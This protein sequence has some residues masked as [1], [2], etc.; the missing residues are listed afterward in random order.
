M[1]PVRTPHASISAELN[2]NSVYPSA[3]PTLASPPSP[4]L[5][6]QVATATS[7]RTT[8]QAGLHTIDHTTSRLEPLPW[9][10]PADDESD[11]PLEDDAV[12]NAPKDAASVR[13]QRV[14]R[15]AAL[16]K[17]IEHMV[18][19]PVPVDQWAV[20]Y[21]FRGKFRDT[22]NVCR[23]LRASKVFKST[24]ERPGEAYHKCQWSDTPFDCK[25]WDTL[26]FTEQHRLLGQ[27]MQ[28]RSM[29][30]Y[31]AGYGPT[32]PLPEGICCKKPIRL[33]PLKQL[34][35]E[36]ANEE[37]RL[38]Y[39]DLNDAIRTSRE[40]GA[41]ARAAAL[42]QERK[43][44]DLP[45]QRSA[46]PGKRPRP[47]D[48]DEE[49]QASS[50]HQ[51]RTLHIDAHAP[52][53]PQESEQPPRSTFHMVDHTVSDTFTSPAS[54]P[55]SNS[56]PSGRT[57][58]PL[59]QSVVPPPQP[60]NPPPQPI[61][62][63]PQPIPP[64]PQ[65]INPPPQTMIDRPLT[66]TTPQSP[67]EKLAHIY[68]LTQ[69]LQYLLE[70]GISFGPQPPSPAPVP[71]NRASVTHAPTP[72]RFV[73]ETPG[74]WSGAS[75]QSVLSD[76]FPP[77]TSTDL[78]DLGQLALNVGISPCS[79]LSPHEGLP[80][81][82][83]SD[84]SIS[85]ISTDMQYLNDAIAKMGEPY[86][87][88]PA[89]TPGPRATSSG[90]S[91]LPPRTPENTASNP[92]GPY[93]SRI[94]AW[95]GAYE[96]WRLASH[97]DAPPSFVDLSLSGGDVP[98][99]APL[100]SG[101]T[102]S[103]ERQ[104]AAP[105]TTSPPPHSSV[106]VYPLHSRNGR[107]GDPPPSEDGSPASSSSPDAAAS[108]AESEHTSD[109]SDKEPAEH[110]VRP[111]Q[112]AEF[113]GAKLPDGTQEDE[114]D[115]EADAKEFQARARALASAY[116]QHRYPHAGGSLPADGRTAIKFARQM[117]RGLIEFICEQ[118]N[119]QQQRVWKE[120]GAFVGW[121]R[122]LN[123]WNMFQ[124]KWRDDLPPG[125]PFDHEAC[126]AAYIEEASNDPVEFHSRLS[127]WHEAHTAPD[128]RDLLPSERAKLMDQLLK[129]S[130]YMFSMYD[131][132][133][134]IGARLEVGS[135]HPLEG[136]TMY[137]VYETKSMQGYTNF[138]YKRTHAG[139]KIAWVAFAA[140]RAHALVNNPPPPTVDRRVPQN[141]RSARAEIQ[142]AGRALARPLPHQLS[143]EL[144]N[145]VEGEIT[146]IWRAFTSVVP[147]Q[148][149][150]V[151]AWTDAAVQNPQRENPPL[152]VTVSGRRWTWQDEQ[153]RLAGNIAE[154]PMPQSMVPEAPQSTAV[155]KTVQHRTGKPK[156]KLRDAH[157]R[158]A[159]KTA[160]SPPGPLR[161]AVRTDVVPSDLRSLTTESPAREVSH[162]PPRIAL[163]RKALDTD[164]AP[165]QGDKSTD[166]PPGR[167][168]RLDGRGGRSHTRSSR[169]DPEAEPPSQA[170]GAPVQRDPVAASQPS[171]RPTGAHPV[172][173]PS[174]RELD[175]MVATHGSPPPSWNQS[176][177]GE[178][179]MSPRRYDVPVYDP[180][181]P[182]PDAGLT[183]KSQQRPRRPGPTY[184]TVSTHAGR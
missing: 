39:E 57:N 14:A 164:A 61:N 62:P 73:P 169:E 148:A 51:R 132:T 67:E 138:A 109:S 111:S 56:Q 59:A 72:S 101:F 142:S 38:K 133:C 93:A 159:P 11:V 115:E 15:I 29:A 141:M 155:Q 166:P 184:A 147:S 92:E 80:G 1:A 2:R 97:W 179:A 41:A 53:T 85:S 99:I 96:E 163:K 63:P 149:L 44:T 7:A 30:D 134:H 130:T 165:L 70:S 90:D 131:R 180:G 145:S 25:F 167:R 182:L 171:A 140:K 173:L 112:D 17:S 125:T 172:T 152:I 32:V 108:D 162:S 82:Q 100:P 66:P 151:K 36:L 42:P 153:G 68:A 58:A 26:A 60:I 28:L 54:H 175:S 161:Q 71:V 170:V 128:G 79:Q 45:A 136:E 91:F 117:V 89:A 49:A 74:A 3:R 150:Y 88:Q 106:P 31:P 13:E 8:I 37:S 95:T 135:L 118:Y 178:A 83:T 110:D 114:E 33:N 98:P 65:T 174:F 27:G 47:E 154:E 181:P 102:D 75:M 69:R 86:I 76:L 19:N 23:H 121:A 119:L 50:S 160:P 12:E 157:K 158:D 9:S 81:M 87:F 176:A 55:P 144:Q 5:S 34:R 48:L 156:R 104:A 103:S 120:V 40:E 64:P 18:R 16:K 137:H 177:I 126:H 4:P 46:S 20:R 116:Y 143:R 10:A 84:S 22:V 113:W 6:P 77:S 168:R 124:R 21:F 139:C 146:P 24:V 129:A 43:R 105:P 94:P 123:A 52:R 122:G 127:A 35:I 183:L 107:G 78:F